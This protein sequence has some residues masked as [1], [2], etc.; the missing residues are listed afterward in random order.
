M[1]LPILSENQ[2]IALSASKQRLLYY[3][4]KLL[5]L[6]HSETANLQQYSIYLLIILAPYL[7]H[8]STFIFFLKIC[9]FLYDHVVPIINLI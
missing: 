1:I 3:K 7:S 2:Y 6:D 4:N 8:S 9:S 5:K